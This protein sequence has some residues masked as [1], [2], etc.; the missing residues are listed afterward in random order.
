MMLCR[1]V[2]SDVGEVFLP[3]ILGPC[4]SRKQLCNAGKCT[5]RHCVM[6]DSWN[7]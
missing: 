6:P 2:V 5:G 3:N 7:H 4:G 1:L